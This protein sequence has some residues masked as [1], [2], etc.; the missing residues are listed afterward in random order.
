MNMPLTTAE[1]GCWMQTFSGGVFHPLNPKPNEIHIEDI[2]ASLSKM[3]RFGGHCRIFYSVAEHCVHL[4]EVAPA[5][6]KLTAL[7]HDASEAYL[8]DIPRPIKPRLANYYDLEA[9]IMRV[10]AD[11][12]GIAW[13]LPQVVKDL[14]TAILSD[15]REQIMMPMDVEGRLWGNTLPKLNKRLHCWEP[16]RASAAFMARFHIY[17]KGE[18]YNG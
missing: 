10:I 11:K 17:A 13:P 9:G 4:A 16:A 12:Y 18:L 8:V 1:D 7:L 14:D 15:E 5:P 6:L 3:C 2:A